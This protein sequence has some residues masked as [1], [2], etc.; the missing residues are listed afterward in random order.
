MKKMK[1]TELKFPIMRNNFKKHYRY[2]RNRDG[3]GRSVCSKAITDL[4]T[5]RSIRRSGSEMRQNCR[6]PNRGGSTAR[7]PRK[8]KITFGRIVE[9]NESLDQSQQ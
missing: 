4:G 5:D 6:E 8:I 9:I 3:Y 2:Y 1:M 7:K